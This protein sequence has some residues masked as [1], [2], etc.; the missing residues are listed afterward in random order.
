MGASRTFIQICVVLICL[1]HLRAHFSCPHDGIEVI[2][3]G[4]AHVTDEIL[5]EKR[6][7]LIMDR[8]IDHNKFVQLSPLRF[9]HIRSYKPMICRSQNAS[10]LVRT[11]ARFTLLYQIHSET[12]NVHMYHPSSAIGVILILRQF[13]TLILPPKWRYVCLEEVCVHELHDCVSLVLRYMRVTHLSQSKPLHAA[14]SVSR[15]PCRPS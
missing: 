15:K 6:P 12:V 3:L 4:V 7:L 11:S 13:Q 1:I 9:L 8:I 5:M 14:T 2:Q 10:L